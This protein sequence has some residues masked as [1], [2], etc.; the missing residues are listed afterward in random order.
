MASE[1]ALLEKIQSGDPNVRTQ[2][3]QSACEV[4]PRP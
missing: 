3:W 4:G 1:A 2:A